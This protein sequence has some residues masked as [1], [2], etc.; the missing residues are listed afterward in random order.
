MRMKSSV[1]DGREITQQPENYGVFLT[2][3]RPP[4]MQDVNFFSFDLF[5]LTGG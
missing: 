5:I 3:Q 2:S 1:E 4:L